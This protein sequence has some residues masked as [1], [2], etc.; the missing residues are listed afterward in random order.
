MSLSENI[1]ANSRAVATVAPDGEALRRRLLMLVRLGANLL[2]QLIAT[3]SS[4]GRPLDPRVR[5]LTPMLKM[6]GPLVE[7]LATTQLQ[8]ATPAQLEQWLASCTQMLRVVGD[9]ALADDACAE[10]LVAI[11]RANS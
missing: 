5:A 11:A 4:S 7:Q 3:S 2:P 9:S 8:K 1:S 6:L 10:Q